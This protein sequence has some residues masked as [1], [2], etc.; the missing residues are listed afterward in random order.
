LANHEL[1]VSLV[2]LRKVLL[3]NTRG[4]LSSFLYAHAAQ[5]NR[6]VRLGD[7]VAF[8]AVLNVQI[9]ENLVA[10]VASPGRL[11]PAPFTSATRMCHGFVFLCDV[12]KMLLDDARGRLFALRAQQDPFLRVVA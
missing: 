12:W 6:I 11:C 9:A 4:P 2:D 10:A 8:I 3:D 7:N 1:G 5:A